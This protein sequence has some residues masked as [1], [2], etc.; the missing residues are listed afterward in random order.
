MGLEGDGSSASLVR[1]T[2]QN[3]PRRKIAHGLGPLHARQ[4]MME[5]HG[6]ALAPW[7]KNTQRE[8]SAE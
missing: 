3:T 5:V 7:G 1:L 6:S 2:R 4:F 8:G